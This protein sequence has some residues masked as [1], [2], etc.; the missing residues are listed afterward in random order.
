LTLA[1]DLF[2]TFVFLA[3]SLSISALL[4]WIVIASF[5]L[6]I[7]VSAIATPL[8]V[9]GSMRN[10]A[11]ARR[12]GI[13][14]ESVTGIDTEIEASSRKCNVDGRSNRG[15]VTA[16]FRLPILATLPASVQLISKVG[17]R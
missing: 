1:I 7:A 8:S 11:A 15:Y 4:T 2:F 3:V 13:F 12:P 5:P 10:F 16:S 14:V 9:S 17:L 6:Y